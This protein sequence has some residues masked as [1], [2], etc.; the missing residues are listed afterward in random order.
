MH[1]MLCN[2]LDFFFH[3]NVHLLTNEEILIKISKR[4]YDFKFLSEK[5]FF[6]WLLFLNGLSYR[7]PIGHKLK[8]VYK[9]FKE[10]QRGKFFFD[11]TSQRA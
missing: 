7:Y 9:S 4:H 8:I 2:Y 10:L 5:F 3:K 11:D 1:F 6:K